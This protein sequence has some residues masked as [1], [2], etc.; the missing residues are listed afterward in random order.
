VGRNLI[1]SYDL[2]GTDRDYTPVIEIIKTLGNWAKIEYSLFYVNAAITAA[3]ARDVVWAKMRAGDRIFV[4]DCT[5]NEAAW[6]GLA[7]EVAQRM[8]T[9][10]PL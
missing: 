1:I 5:N 4:A 7:D 6:Y 8:R 10:W 2:V 3:D 9:E